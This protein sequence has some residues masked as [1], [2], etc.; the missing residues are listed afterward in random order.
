MTDQRELNRMLGAFF[1]TGSDELADRVIDAALVQIDH[2]RQRRAMRVPRRLMTMNM[3]TRLAAAAVIGVLAIG[4]AL[5]LLRP[6]PSGVGTASP[7]P[8]TTA[9]QGLPTATAPA[10]TPT[11]KPSPMALTGALGAGRQ[12]HSAALLAD[13]RVLVAGGLDVGDAPLASASLYDPRTGSFSPTGSMSIAR[14]F[15]TATLLADGRVLVAGGGPPQWNHPG[16]DLASAELYDPATGTFSSTGSM[17]TTRQAHTAT[18]LRDGRVLITGGTDT[19]DQTVATAELYDPRTGKFSLTG[20]MSTA[21]GY[22]TATLL[23]D[24]RVLV[25]GGDPCGW[26]SCARLATAEVYDPKTGTFTATGSL[27]TDR[28]FHTATLL[29]DGRVLIAG[30][31]SSVT[32]LVSAELYDP[33][34]G[35]F[36]ATGPMST[37]RVYTT[38][39][40]LADGRVLVAGGGGDYGN[41]E[42]LD[43]AE[44]FDPATG[45]FTKT[46]SM[47]EQR[48]YQTSTLLSD[49]RVLIAGGYGNL[50]PLASAELYDPTTGKFSPAGTGN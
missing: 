36:S 16:P 37:P 27:A 4:G 35:T 34:T 10:P 7:T 15:F 31:D 19:G 14:A 21:R 1:A 9:T 47:T 43:S 33:K 13:G 48:T 49:G 3:P 24:G 26:A 39:S 44:I 45:K 20:S 32:Y 25:A 12:I 40:L 46:G 22:H 28:G 5:Y 23:A 30:G 50:A 2:T 11:A 42:F 29:H 8:S 18:L 6:G 17:T 38:S 41:R